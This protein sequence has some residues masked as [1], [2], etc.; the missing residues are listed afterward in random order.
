ML[1]EFDSYDIN[2]TKLAQVLKMM[3]DYDKL[4]KPEWMKFNWFDIV[5]IL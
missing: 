1:F 2:V 3:F 5:M 4:H